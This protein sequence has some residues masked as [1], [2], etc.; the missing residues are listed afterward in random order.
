VRLSLPIL[1]LDNFASIFRWLVLGDFLFVSFFFEFK[2]FLLGT[3][4]LNISGNEQIHELFPFFS[5]LELALQDEDFSG[6][7]PE[8]GGNSFRNSVVARDNDINVLQRSVGVAEGDSGNVDVTGL[9]N[10]LAVAFRVSNHQKSGLL[11]FL[12]HL[13][14]EGTWNPSG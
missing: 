12:G 11:E 8:D 6:K 13:I 9:N 1:L 3:D 14:G 10:S 7:H 2:L 4:C 5:L